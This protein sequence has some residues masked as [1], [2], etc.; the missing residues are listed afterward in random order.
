MTL[1]GVSKKLVT[2]VQYS[3]TPIGTKF[4]HHTVPQSVGNVFTNVTTVETYKQALRWR[5]RVDQ[6]SQLENK[7]AKRKVGDWRQDAQIIPLLDT[8]RD[9]PT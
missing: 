6:G 9:Q 4:L 7:G 3:Q 8:P 5:L 1:A 2:P